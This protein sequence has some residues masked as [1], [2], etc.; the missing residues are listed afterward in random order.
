MCGFTLVEMIMVIV[1]TG[2]LGGMVAVFLKA[3]VQQYMDVA[4]RADMTDIADTALR[5]IGRDLRLALPNSVRV[6]TSGAGASTVYYL[7]F[8]VTSGGGRYR[9]GAGGTNDILDFTIAD[10]SFEVLG[11]VPTCAANDQ[12]VVYNLG[13][14]DADA[15]AGDNR[16]TCTSVA[17]PIVNIAAMQFPFESPNARFQIVHEQ[18]RYICDPVAQ[19][20]SRYSFAGNAIEV[21]S[22]TVPAGGAL[23]AKNVSACTVTYDPIVVAQRS[24]LVSMNL[25]ITR[26]GETVTLYNAT[27]VSNVP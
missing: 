11:A 18:V 13:I 4:R 12:V 14:T 1:I 3:P 20:L 26:D 10:T 25:A 9:S 6:Q 17:A 19:T 15:Y 22:A 8:L 21:P 2:I 27:H 7:D 5:R 16:T 23:L 24:G